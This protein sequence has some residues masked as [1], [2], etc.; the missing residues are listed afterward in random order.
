MDVSFRAASEE[1][2]HWKLGVPQE[3]SGA[4][5][6]LGDQDRR[7]PLGMSALPL[8]VAHRAEN[9]GPAPAASPQM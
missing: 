7:V 4:A 2:R 1:L 3:T 6:Q 9:L 5:R 8:V